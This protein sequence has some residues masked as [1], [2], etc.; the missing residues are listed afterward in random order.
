MLHAIVCRCVLK[1]LE[2]G[3]DLLRVVVG[4][5]VFTEGESETIAEGE[6]CGFGELD[7]A[8]ALAIEMAICV[9]DVLGR[10]AMRC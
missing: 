8:Q 2:R 5:G 6:A 9:D 10:H 3:A 1:E 7:G 4:W